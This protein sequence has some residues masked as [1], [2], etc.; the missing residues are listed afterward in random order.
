[1]GSNIKSYK[2]YK[3][4]VFIPKKRS[5]F[6]ETDYRGLVVSTLKQKYHYFIIG[7]GVLLGL[8]TATSYLLLNNASAGAIVAQD[9]KTVEAT[10]VEK[11]DIVKTA[12]T[13]KPA[14][15]AVEV[16]KK[17]EVDPTKA[18]EA[19]STKPGQGHNKYVVKAGDTLWKIAERAYK[20]GFNY[21]DVVAYNK[22][23]N[24]NS[25]IVG[26]EILLPTVAPELPTDP[27]VLA[28][29][30]VGGP[31]VQGEIA[32]GAMTG[33]VTNTSANYSVVKGDTLWNIAESTL[34]DGFAWKD[35]AKANGVSDPIRL[36]VGTNLVIPR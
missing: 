14:K 11:L 5:A 10:P 3:S 9:T 17:P 31:S 35:I 4:T 18:A 25:I 24:P 33:E 12:V 27:S 20:S 36:K 19:A 6:R 34:G 16:V 7:I 28:R 30:G 29:G 1:M 15:E 2:K 26:Q 21:K 32:E 22:I 8:I 13:P 23:R